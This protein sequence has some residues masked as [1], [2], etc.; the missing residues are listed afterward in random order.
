MELLQLDVKMAFL[1]G[2]FYEKIYMV[3]LKCFV[4]QGKEHLVCKLKNSLYELKQAPRECYNK[5]DAFIQFQG[6]KKSEIDHYLYTKRAKDNNL[7]LLALYVD[8]MLLA[9]KNTYEL[10]H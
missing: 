4:E 10:M 8:D 9:S 3:Q 2:D 1:H 6:F 5:F 7:I